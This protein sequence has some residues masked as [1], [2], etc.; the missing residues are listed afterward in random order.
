FVKT[1]TAHEK[2]TFESMCTNAQG[3]QDMTNA[4]A[5]IA[6]MSVVDKDGNRIFE[7]GDVDELNKKSGRAIDRIFTVAC[8]LSGLRRE[9]MEKAVGNSSG[10]GGASP[11]V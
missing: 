1:M 11:S 5:I 8:R 10:Q 6:V 3:V 4:R 7:L 2:D 9:D